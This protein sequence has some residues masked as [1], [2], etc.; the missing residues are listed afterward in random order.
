MIYLSVEGLS[1]QFGDQ[2]LFEGLKFSI[3]KGDKVGL[4]AQ[5]GAGK[6][7]PLELLA[8]RNPPDAGVVHPGK[9]IVLGYLEQDP[10]MDNSMSIR[11]FIDTAHT[12]M[13]AVIRNY[14][15]ALAKQTE[16]Q[17]VQDQ[18]TLEQ[19]TAE[20]DALNAWDYRRRLEQLLTRFLLRDAA[21]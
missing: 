4:I 19:A 5:N 16:S 9:G 10:E 17:S 20:M 8:G 1:Q 6:S 2:P 11:E 15:Q 13:T 3:N 7:T 18:K 14:E 12:A 21:H